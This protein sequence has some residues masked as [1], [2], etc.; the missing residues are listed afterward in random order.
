MNNENEMNILISINSKFVMPAT[1]MLASLFENNKEHITVYMLYSDL[2]ISEIKK[3][4]EYIQSYGNKLI[5]LKLNS[6]IFKSVPLGK[7]FSVEAYYRLIAHEILPK[8]LKR[9]LYL[10]SDLIINRSIKKFYNQDIG[11][12]Y[13]VS[14]E[15]IDISKKNKIIYR[16]INLPKDAKYFNSGVLLY[17]LEL[18]RKEVKFQKILDYI[19]ENK[20]NIVWV[21][22]DV[23][24]GMFYDKV[25][26]DDFK[27]Y[28]LKVPA[29]KRDKKSIDYVYHNSVIIHFTG[30]TKPWNREYNE[31]FS[32]FLFGDL[33]WEYIHLTPY[34]HKYF[35]FRIGSIFNKI[36]N[37]I[38]IYLRNE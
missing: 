13:F 22:Q 16:K 31:L 1:V 26:F 9:I 38:S 4:K 30:P 25:K 35:Y 19:S 24:N 20:K 5:L 28:N 37:L 21:D 2:K 8:N 34:K 11:Q 14:C 18:I 10:D 6:K 32:R 3:I 23:L 36:L 33:F 17:N 29:V 7:H 15:D 12:N 27:L